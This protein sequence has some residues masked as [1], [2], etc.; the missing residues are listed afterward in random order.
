LVRTRVT[1]WP[2]REL[3]TLR[4]RLD[5]LAA[6]VASPQADLEEE[7]RALL[8][9]FLIVRSCG[10]VEQT[11]VSVS[12]AFV[13]ER[14]G[15]PVKAFA[16]SHLSRSANPSAEALLSTVGRFDAD[17]TEEFRELLDEDDERVRRDLGVLVDRRHKIAH[18]LNETVRVPRALELH[19]AAC[20]LSDWFIKRFNPYRD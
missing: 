15:G 7:V 9:R 1:Q 5:E 13:H 2:P 14:S 4:E 11:V 16:A 18:G 20:E 19:G 12:R 6:I 8:A 10:F 17:W 3:I